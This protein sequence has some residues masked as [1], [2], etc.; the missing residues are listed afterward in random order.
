MKT[1]SVNV[2]RNFV[3]EVTTTMSPQQRGRA[4]KAQMIDAF[5]DNT[6]PKTMSRVV[7]D[8]DRSR[9]ESKK[10]RSLAAVH[11]EEDIQDMIDEDESSSTIKHVSRA[12]AI[13]QLTDKNA[14]TYQILTVFS[15]V[16]LVAQ[17][18][19]CEILYNN[20]NVA[21]KTC[22]ALKIVGSVMTLFLLRLLWVYYQDL[23]ALGK[24]KKLYEETEDLFTTKLYIWLFVELFICAIHPLPFVGGT[25]VLDMKSSTEGTEIIAE[26]TWDSILNIMS[27]TRLYLLFRAGH[28]LVGFSTQ[29]DARML[30]MFNSVDIGPWFTFKNAITQYPFLFVSFQLALLNV[31]SAY[32]LREAERPVQDGFEYYWNALWCSMITIT[33]VGYGDLYPI[34][35]AGRGVIVVTSLMGTAILALLI[36]AVFEIVQFG[37]SERKMQAMLYKSR[38]KR[39]MKDVSVKLITSTLRL[40]IMRKRMA[41]A[42][43]KM[44]SKGRG[45]AA[46]AIAAQS[47]TEN[48]LH[49]AVRAFRTVSR[50]LQTV[51]TNE[52]A[53]PVAHIAKSMSIMQNADEDRSSHLATW[54]QSVDE[55]LDAM[56]QS[57]NQRLD[58]LQDSLNRLLAG[59]NQSTDTVSS[60]LSP[61]GAPQKQV[62]ESLPTGSS[63]DR[64]L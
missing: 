11:V 3:S 58:S 21:T 41:Q 64:F 5:N 42:K 49:R 38:L 40:K 54:Q 44:K 62:L 30:A 43:E 53:D 63:E 35:H 26:Y 19:E 22:E 56:Q 15:L 39:E 23:L 27:L 4:I 33:T 31:V 36:S 6:G 17:V 34:S 61:T 12:V 47:L 37:N 29:T 16:G 2:A 9:T 14:R 25:F 48:L 32:A 13:E 20:G 60:R 57:T 59:Q 50:E 52:D 46:A 7:S 45:V 8:E 1:R 24:C 10:M 55:R 28:F 51:N 18:V